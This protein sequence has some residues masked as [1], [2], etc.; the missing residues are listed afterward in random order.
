MFAAIIYGYYEYNSCRK[1][2]QLI[3]LSALTT[4]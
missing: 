2:F 1:L 3:N 4:I